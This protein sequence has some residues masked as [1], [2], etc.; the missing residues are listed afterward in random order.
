MLDILG[1]KN[2]AT[3]DPKTAKKARDPLSKILSCNT[4]CLS[5]YIF[6]IS[7][8]LSEYLQTKR[9]YYAAA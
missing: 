8:P 2:Q 3:V 9:L 5:E 1:S 6:S 4:I 7:I